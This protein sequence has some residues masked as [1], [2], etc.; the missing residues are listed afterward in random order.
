VTEALAVRLA[1]LTSSYPVE[2]VGPREIRSESVQ[3]AEQAR[4]VSGR[5]WRWREAFL[6]RTIGFA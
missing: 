4:K 1:Q 2:I 5:I 6:S 3:D